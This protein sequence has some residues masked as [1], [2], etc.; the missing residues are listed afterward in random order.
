MTTDK[1]PRLFQILYTVGTILV[2]V[3]TL[4]GLLNVID[5]SVA[6]TAASLF[7]LLAG[8]VGTAGLGAATRRITHQINNGWFDGEETKSVPAAPSAP[9]PPGWM[10]AGVPNLLPEGSA[11]ANAARLAAYLDERSK[12][13]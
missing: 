10:Q 6:V 8:T 5:D 3:L 1:N 7:K 11:A 12:K 13:P 4:L 9:V 2:G